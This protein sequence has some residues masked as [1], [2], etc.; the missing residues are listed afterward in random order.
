MALFECLS[1]LI[2][3]LIHNLAF[4]NVPGH[5]YTIMAILVFGDTQNNKPD[6]LIVTELQN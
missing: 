2:I 4:V 1:I 6:Y 5:V 3:S